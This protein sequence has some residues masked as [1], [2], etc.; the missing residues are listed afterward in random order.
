M[1]RGRPARPAPPTPRWR[2]SATSSAGHLDLDARPGDRLVYP[3]DLTGH[4]R[5]VVAADRRRTR[6]HIT[7]AQH[8]ILQHLDERIGQRGAVVNRYQPTALTVAQ[9]TPKGIQVA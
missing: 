9:H 8:V 1:P 3:H 5:P 7:F 4:H 6:S 2:R